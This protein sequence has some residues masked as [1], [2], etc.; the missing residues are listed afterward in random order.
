MFKTIDRQESTILVSL[1][2]SAAFDMIDHHTLIRLH[3]SFCISDASLQWNT[4]YLSATSQVVGID[5]ARSPVSACSSGVPQGSVLGPILLSLYIAPIAPLASHHG[6][7][8]QKYA[9]DTQLF[10]SLS[11]SNHTININSLQHCLSKLHAWYCH[12]GLT[13]NADKSN[14]IIVGTRQQ[15]RTHADLLQVNVAE[16]QVA[17]STL[18]RILGVTIDKN[19]TIDD[20]VK[21]VCKNSYYHKQAP[22]RILPMLTEDIV[23]SVACLL[24]NA[25]L[26]YAN[27]VQFGVT[28]K[29]ILKLQMVQNTLARV[30]TGLQHHKHITPT[31]KRL[32]LVWTF[33]LWTPNYFLP[34][35]CR[36]QINLYHA[37][38]RRQIN[39][40]QPLSWRGLFWS[41][42]NVATP[43]EL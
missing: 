38:A 35:S 34:N 1:H 16:A 7:L 37:T 41:L 11:P 4:S 39:F 3:T 33:T 10:K 12:N 36:R 22:R 42:E 19:M 18:T 23:N 29:N 43:L 27:S 26:H 31:F 5:L 13:L 15:L 30:V 21:S 25:R 9:D 14:V 32:H 6:V 20:Y 24:V 8:P 17:V 2:L 28:S 40:R